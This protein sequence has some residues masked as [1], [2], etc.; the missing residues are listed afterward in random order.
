VNTNIHHTRQTWFA[1]VPIFVTL[2]KLDL[3]ESQLQRNICC[4]AKIADILVK[5]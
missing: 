4:L 3:R 2:A 1:R 5:I